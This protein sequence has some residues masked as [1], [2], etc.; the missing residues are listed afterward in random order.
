MLNNF[1]TDLLVITVNGRIMSDWGETATPVT[2]EPIDPK[3]RSFQVI[4]T[5]LSSNFH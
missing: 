3:R 5:S 1:S 2:D 4:D